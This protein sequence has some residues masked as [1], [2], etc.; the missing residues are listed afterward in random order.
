MTTTELEIK[1]PGGVMRLKLE[2]FFPCTGRDL[3]KLFRTTL[4][5]SPDYTEACEKMEAYLNKA[6]A[7]VSDVVRLKEY[8]NGYADYHEKYKE[9]LEEV[10][11]MQAD[12][13]RNK[14]AMNNYERSSPQYKM[15]RTH[16]KEKKDNLS[17]KKELLKFYKDCATENKR[18]FEKLVRYQKRYRENLKLLMELTG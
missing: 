10:A 15:L 3:R 4:N 14:A 1:Y 13:D 12:S 6:L 9:K 2:Q 7:D 17:A 18:E 5:A 11:K 16:Y 8:A